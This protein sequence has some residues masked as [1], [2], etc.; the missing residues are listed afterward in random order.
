MKVG[1][2]RVEPSKLAID[3]H[4]EADMEIVIHKVTKEAAEFAEYTEKLSN[5]EFARAQ[6]S[7]FFKANSSVPKRR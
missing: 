5:T 6:N 4:K 7:A 2:I 3:D 1:V